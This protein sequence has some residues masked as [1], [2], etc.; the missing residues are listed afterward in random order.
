MQERVSSTPH[1]EAGQVGS[2]ECKTHGDGKESKRKPDSEVQQGWHS[3][4]SDGLWLLA[5]LPGL[6]MHLARNCDWLRTEITILQLLDYTLMLIFLTPPLPKFNI[7]LQEGC[8][9]QSVT[10]LI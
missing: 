3:S 4:A 6:F 7:E 9:Y 5:L 2:Q 1:V 10:G 8:H